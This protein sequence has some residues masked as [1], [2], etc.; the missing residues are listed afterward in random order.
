MEI[1]I[2]LKKSISKEIVWKDSFNGK[3]HQNENTL[4]NW[5]IQLYS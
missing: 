2:N 3:N 1:L 5:K 4:K